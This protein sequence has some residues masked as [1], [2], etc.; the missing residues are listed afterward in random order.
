MTADTAD[1]DDAAPAGLW[2][3]ALGGGSPLKR[4]SES[5][6]KLLLLAIVAAVAFY[7]QPATGRV[8]RRRAF[9]RAELTQVPVAGG[10]TIVW[11]VL[12]AFMISRSVTKTGLG[13]RIAFGFIRLL[14]SRSLGLAYA[15]VATDTV[16]ASIVPSN[17]A[18]AGGI[19]FPIAAAWPTRTSAAGQSGVAGR[20]GEGRVPGGLGRLRDV[21]TARRQRHHAK[22]TLAT[23][24]ASP[25]TRLTSTSCHASIRCCSSSI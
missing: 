24:G 20:S 2:R 17:S 14:G 22:F 7:L 9:D 4:R 10:D 3:W 21:P 5:M 15:L 16:L 25:P 13:R 23:G 12:C 1:A 8:S 19:V 11:L 6:K 18:R